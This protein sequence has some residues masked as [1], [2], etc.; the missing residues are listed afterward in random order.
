MDL[1]S[2]GWPVDVDIV[3]APTAAP[4][5]EADPSGLIAGAGL[6]ALLTACGG[7]GGGGDTGSTAPPAPAPAPAPSPAP[8][9]APAPAPTGYTYKTPA[10]DQDAVRFLLQAQFS[11]SDAEI[12]A[13]RSSGYAA[14]L[15]TQIAAAPGPTATSWLDSK[16][17]NAIVPLSRSYFSPGPADQMAWAQL[18]TSPDAP[19]RRMALALSEIFVTSTNVMNGYWPAYVMAAYWDVLCANAFGNY[20]TLLEAI[21]LNL[22]MGNYLNTRGNKKADGKGSAPDENYAREVMQL[23]TI[24]LVMLNPDGTPKRDATGATIDTYSNADITEVAK[25]FT[26]YDTD[27]SQNNPTTSNPVNGGGTDNVPQTTFARLPMVQKG[28]NHSPESKVFFQNTPGVT[29]V[30]IAAGTAAADALKTTLDALFNHPNNA[31]FI[32]KQLIQRLV[33]SNPSP[34]YVQRVAAVYADNGKGVRGDLGAVYAAILQDDEAR[35]PAGLTAV[36]YG[37]VREPMLRLVQWA[38]T[39]RATSD[40]TDWTKLGDYTDAGSRLGQSPLRSPSV[41]NFFR[42][43]YVPPGTSLSTGTVAPEFQ[44][45]SES[46]VAGYLNFMQATID[47][48]GITGLQAAYTAEIALAE[49]PTAANPVDLVNRIHLLMSAGQLSSATLATIATAVGSMA[50]TVA[51]NAASTATN[52]R[53][54]VCATVL[55]VMASAEYLV[56][57]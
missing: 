9:P 17:A 56:Q 23:F 15:K 26:G 19:R 14:W 54:R 48:G 2:R 30:N 18:M 32:S 52:L 10:S 21:T 16:G 51:G 46:S 40:S 57:K 50:G 42:P 4:S 24:G 20:R 6:A 36:E 3:T 1:D 13:V 47:T 37:K 31:P 41:F 44:L 8:A 39:F 12:A 45:V 33:T 25:V 29:P 28:N 35:G 49:S 34:A 5:P 11:A 55:M 38:R 22:A 7:G 43:G 53:R 27:T